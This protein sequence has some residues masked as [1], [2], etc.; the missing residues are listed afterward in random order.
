M[1]TILLQAPGIPCNPRSLRHR[2]VAIA[3]MLCMFATAPFA[4]SVNPEDLR[5]L[6]AEALKNGAASVMVHLMNAPLSELMANLP[7]VRSRAGTQARLLLDELGDQAWSAG[8]SENGVGQL[9]AYVTPKGLDVLV[10]SSNAIAFYPGKSW[11][12]RTSM[13]STDGALEAL[14]AAVDKQ[15]EVDVDLVLNADGMA[16]STAADGRKAFQADAAH[17]AA[18]LSAAEQLFSSMGASELTNQ[19]DVRVQLQAIGRQ[20]AA[21]RLQARLTRQGLVRLADSAVVRSMKP[22]GFVDQRARHFDASALSRARQSG[23]ADV[24]LVLRGAEVGG[25]L[26]AASLAAAKTTNRAALDELLSSRRSAVVLKDFSEFGA[27]HVQLSAADLEWMQAS[28]DR[29]LLAVVDNKP[30]ASPQV[31]VSGPTM[32]LTSAWTAGIRGSGQNVIIFDT[33]TQT[34]HPFLAGRVNFE[35][36]FG[37][38]QFDSGTQYFSECP[39]RNPATGDSPLGLVGSAAPP[40]GAACTLN[41]SPVCS[42]GTHVAGIA[43]GRFAPNQSSGLQGVAPDAGILA[44]QVFSFDPTRNVGPRAFGADLLAGFQAAA[45]AM[46]P[47]APAS[48]PYTLNFSLGGGQYPGT[49]SSI[50]FVPFIAAVQSLR[51]AGVPV[52]AATGNDGYDSA[53]AYP[54][55]LPGVVKV[56]GVANDSIGNSRSF[57]NFPQGANVANP[58]AFPGEAFWFAPGGGTG[59]GVLSSVI[60]GG[61]QGLQ[62]TSMASPQIAGLYADAKSADP[63]LTVDGI[64]NYF[65]GNAAVNVPVR[66]RSGASLGFNLPRIVLPAL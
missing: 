1:N 56:S 6:K 63:N 21:P 27:L 49:C 31:T 24:L 55:C 30:M 58:L 28:R 20:Q 54:A 13:D 23:S 57:F 9:T 34:N 17:R 42:H 40:F 11:Q 51:A 44:I 47:G 14:S 26:S 36:C 37:S 50:E 45:S 62:G 3:A 53:M 35:A 12:R 8:R 2:S 64:T 52:V 18:A 66:A 61:Y 4:A 32:N 15:R 33:G 25:N 65:I 16:I 41:A 38:N 43:A 19:A 29:R 48:N 7:S 39:Q 60:G 22:L 5:N 59:T 46:V 10:A